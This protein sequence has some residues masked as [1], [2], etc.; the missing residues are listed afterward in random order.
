M[1]PLNSAI[2][3]ES[4]LALIT[5]HDPLCRTESPR[6]VEERL[7][8][9]NQIFRIRVGE[10]DI[11]LRVRHNAR[12]F[13]YEKGIFKE[14]VAARLLAA[15]KQDRQVHLDGIL[16]EIWEGTVGSHS[17]EK[18]IFPAGADIF[19]YDFTNLAF[20]GPW[21]LFDWAGDTLGEHFNAEHAARLGASVARIH[22]LKFRHAYKSLDFLRAGGVDL[23]AA[24]ME[25]ILRRNKNTGV[26]ISDEWHLFR[27]LAALR[28]EIGSEPISYVLCHNDLQCTNITMK[29]GELRIVDW[30]N[31]AIAPRELDFVKLAHWS[32]I[33][34]DG[35]FEPDAAIFEAYCEGYGIS[36]AE[37]R[38]SPIFRLAEIL[39]L[40]RVYEFALRPLEPG[41]A[42]KPFWTLWRYASLLRKRLSRA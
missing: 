24:W 22:K 33:G 15:F 26:S 29:D 37:I 13:Q 3:E 39:W 19:H 27:L 16:L 10:R 1:P 17:G 6:V 23:M 41:T 5:A 21:A 12:D 38:Q 14:V 35:Y 36:S 20:S 18:I 11:A 2:D 7:G 40:F 42:K 31:A 28:D 9:I 25:E 4:I 8:S 32:K 30:D 34:E